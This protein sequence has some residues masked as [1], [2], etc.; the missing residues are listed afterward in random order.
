MAIIVSDHQTT[1][2]AKDR[3]ATEGPF[4]MSHSTYH[5][6]PAICKTPFP[7]NTVTKSLCTR[8][9]S[10]I[11]KERD[12]AKIKHGSTVSTNCQPCCLLITPLLLFSRVHRIRTQIKLLGQSSKRFHPHPVQTSWASSN[13]YSQLS[14]AAPADLQL[15]FFLQGED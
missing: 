8:S 13:A 5:I 9:S 2:C 12:S 3:E 6:A 4:P 7:V 14:R 11:S 10:C 15:S 1:W